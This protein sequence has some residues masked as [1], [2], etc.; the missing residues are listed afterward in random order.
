MHGK[1]PASPLAM[2]AQYSCEEVLA[3]LLAPLSRGVDP[4]WRGK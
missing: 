2:G 1:I 3:G 4:N